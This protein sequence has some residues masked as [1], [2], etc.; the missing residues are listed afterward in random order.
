MNLSCIVIED[1]LPAYCD[2]TCTADSRAAV[3]EHLADC[4]RCRRF[5]TALH[6]PLPLEEPRKNP[7]PLRSVEKRWKKEKRIDLFRGGILALFVGVAV[8]LVMAA[9]SSILPHPR[10]H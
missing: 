7:P 1:L 4:P 5:Y 10:K 8:F 2:G 6:R 9:Y 3:E